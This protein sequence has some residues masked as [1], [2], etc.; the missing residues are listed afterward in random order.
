M[1]EKAWLRRVSYAREPRALKA[2]SSPRT[3]KFP[4]IKFRTQDSLVTRSN[5][6]TENTGR[7]KF[8][9]G[10]PRL[11]TRMY[12]FPPIFSSPSLPFLPSI[13][14]GG[15]TTCRRNTAVSHCALVCSKGVLYERGGEL[16]GREI[17]AARGRR[18]LACQGTVNFRCRLRRLREGGLHKIRSNNQLTRRKPR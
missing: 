4:G 2:S 3:R 7:R 9:R 16:P 15:V 14:G 1:G 17:H 6:P 11:N 5:I 12:I 10:V 8:S 13:G 18:K